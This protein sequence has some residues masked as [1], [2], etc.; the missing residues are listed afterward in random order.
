M[1]K[2]I[3]NQENAH[4]NRNEISLHTSA[5]MALVKELLQHLSTVSGNVNVTPTVGNNVKVP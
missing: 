2:I 1:L 5:R 4:Q 3:N